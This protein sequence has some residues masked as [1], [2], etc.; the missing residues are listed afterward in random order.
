MGSGLGAVISGSLGFLFSNAGALRLA[1][2][3]GHSFSNGEAPVAVA[4][5]R[6]SWLDV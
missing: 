6:H 3:M 5:E 4:V 2:G 1:V